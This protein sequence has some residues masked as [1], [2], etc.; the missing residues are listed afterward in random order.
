[1]A[2]HSWLGR[3]RCWL[4]VAIPIFAIIL[5]HQLLIHHNKLRVS[6]TRKEPDFAQNGRQALCGV[7]DVLIILKTGVTEAL[8]KVPIHLQTTLQHIPNYAIFS[9]FEETISGVETHDVLRTIGE[10]IKRTNPDFELYRRI[11]ELG[12]E[13]LKASDL[14]LD[15]VSG[16]S[17]KPN[18]P[19]W[20]LDK[21]KFI[22]MIDEALDVRPDAK[23]FVFI[24]ADTYV[25]WS[26]LLA[27]LAMLDATKSYYLGTQ[28]RL[29][30]LV[31]GYGGSGF[32]LSNSAMKKFSNYR[33]SR[34]AELDDYTA[35][36]WAGDAVLG[37]TMADAGIPLTY[38]WPMLQTARIWNLDHFGDL[39]CYP[40][41]S[42]H[43]MTPGDVEIM[44]R[45]DQQWSRNVS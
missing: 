38:S 16:P 20:K 41:V 21:W 32:V 2:T 12:R 26:N 17:G 43:H 13:G 6:L 40:V 28:M 31:F 44:W 34:T 25:V 7:D 22:P 4:F 11:K 37:K 33:A 35:S 14:M 29:G 42:Y 24:E 45:F 39:W 9:D 36:Q 5:L 30:S 23:W 1:M 18:N 27:W 10:D 8:E 3:W 15:D 19:G